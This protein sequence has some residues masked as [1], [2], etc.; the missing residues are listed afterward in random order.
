MVS[1]Y[2]KRCS[3]SVAIR[4]IWIKTTDTNYFTPIR[5]A[6]IKMTIPS[7]CE[8]VEKSEHLSFT[9]GTVKRF[10]HLGK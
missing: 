10:S 8:N 2:M 9:G 6:K 4:E 3:T 5:I 7:T 1:K